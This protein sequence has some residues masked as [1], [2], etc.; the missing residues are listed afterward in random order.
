MWE[1]K[2]R[3]QEERKNKGRSDLIN[4]ILEENHKRMKIEVRLFK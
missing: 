2:K 1:K 4:K 3:D